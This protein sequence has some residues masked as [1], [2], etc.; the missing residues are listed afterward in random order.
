MPAADDPAAPTGPADPVDRAARAGLD[1]ET[2][3]ARIA[4]V[5][6]EIEARGLHS[7][8]LVFAD[9][10]GLLRGKSLRADL[11][12]DAFRTGIGI[13]S[14]LLIK[15]TGQ[16]NIYPV[17]AKGAGL[18]K[19]WLS[20]AGDVFMVPDPSTFRVLPW[21]DGSGWLLCDLVSPDGE[22]VELSTRRI[23]AQAEQA[24]SDQGYRFRAGLEIEFHLYRLGPDDQPGGEPGPIGHLHPGYVYLSELRYDLIEPALEQIRNHLT[25]LG[26]PPRSLELELGPSQVELTFDP[27]GGLDVADQAVLVRSAIKQI[28]R[29]NDLLATFMGRPNLPRSFSSGWHL[30]QSLVEPGSGANLFALPADEHPADDTRAEPPLSPTGLAYAAGVL[31]AATESCLLTTPTVTGYKRYRADSLAPHRVAWATQHRGAMLRFIGGPGDPGTRIENRVGD[32]AANPYLYLA[33]QM[34]AGLSGI[35][36]QKVL[37]PGADSPYQAE[38]G[39]TLPASLGQAIEAFESSKLFR[40]TLGDEFV[41]YLT[42]LKRAEWNRFLATVTDWEQDEYLELF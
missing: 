13:T 9:P 2:R 26:L 21:T 6:A 27:A 28:A 41:D 35:E 22:P 33:S 17:W 16:Q 38:A 37:P 31:E 3:Q 25:A 24:L 8:R 11:V 10:H 1:G 42:T 18:G 12:A 19:P 7:V 20:G 36:Q 14:A 4:E 34:L 40:S 39:P 30:H 5:L 32:S 29:R 15:D 23:C